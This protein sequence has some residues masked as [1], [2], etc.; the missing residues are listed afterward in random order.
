MKTLQDGEQDWKSFQSNVNSAMLN[1]NGKSGG[2]HQK[3]LLRNASSMKRAP[4]SE[5]HVSGLGFT[6]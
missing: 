3:H 4:T 6:F 5:N 1:G 2:Q